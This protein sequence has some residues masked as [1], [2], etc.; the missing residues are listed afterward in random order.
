MVG[1]DWSP[2]ILGWGVIDLDATMTPFSPQ[3][4][5]FLSVATGSLSGPATALTMSAQLG[6]FPTNSP[7]GGVCVS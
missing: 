2:R 1:A 3:P 6:A 7:T 4:P 5:V